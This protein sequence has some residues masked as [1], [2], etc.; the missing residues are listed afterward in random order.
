MNVDSEVQLGKRNRQQLENHN[1][2]T[3]AAEQESP[4]TDSNLTEAYPFI[5]LEHAKMM[6]GSQKALT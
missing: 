5:Y 2:A 4:D 6:A 3:I 1:I